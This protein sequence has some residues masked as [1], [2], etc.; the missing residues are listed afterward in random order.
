MSKCSLCNNTGFVLI[1]CKVHNRYYDYAY[2]CL[3]S[4]G[5]EQKN[6]KRATRERLEKLRYTGKRFT[7]MTMEEEREMHKGVEDCEGEDEVE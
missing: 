6:V 2:A 1:E 5:F 7:E 4:E 3:C